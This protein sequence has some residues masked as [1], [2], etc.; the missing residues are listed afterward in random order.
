MVS[1]EDREIYKTS[2]G[3]RRRGRRGELLLNH[4]QI[5]S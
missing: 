3:K 4:T 5:S 1:G 2:R